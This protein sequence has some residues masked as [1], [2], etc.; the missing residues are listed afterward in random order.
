MGQGL[1]ATVGSRVTSISK[2][3]AFRSLKQAYLSYQYLYKL[4]SPLQIALLNCFLKLFDP[5]FFF[6]FISIQVFRI[7]GFIFLL[8]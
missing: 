4:P 2:I 6:P 8:N 7:V 1:L 5:K 3:K